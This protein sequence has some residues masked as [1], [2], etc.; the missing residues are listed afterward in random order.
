MTPAFSALGYW[1]AIHSHVLSLL[2]RLLIVFW[3]LVLFLT[4]VSCSRSTVVESNPFSPNITMILKRALKAGFFELKESPPPLYEFICSLK[5]RQAS[6][7]SDRGFFSMTGPRIR[8]LF[9]NFGLEHFVFTSSAPNFSSESN[10]NQIWIRLTLPSFLPMRNT[11][12]LR[13]ESTN[14]SEIKCLIWS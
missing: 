11:L 9:V 2:L 12:H 3:G 8:G 7:N 6:S 10:P 4:F 5:V 13:E 1:L 14:Y